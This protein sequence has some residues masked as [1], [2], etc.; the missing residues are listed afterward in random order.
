MCLVSIRHS[1]S[2]LKYCGV[3]LYFFNSRKKPRETKRRMQLLVDF[4]PAPGFR[5]PVNM[6]CRLEV[7]LA[8]TGHLWFGQ[9][10]TNASP[11]KARYWVSGQRFC[12]GHFWMHVNLR[13]QL[14]TYSSTTFQSVSNS[15]GKCAGPR[16]IYLP[17]LIIFAQT[18][19]S[20]MLTLLFPFLNFFF[21][22]EQQ[23][24]ECFL[25]TCIQFY[26]RGD[27]GWL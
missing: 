1:K 26:R 16:F 11:F 10:Y 25:H 15:C 22:Y 6:L 23:S 4:S 13:V 27:R 17:A 19:F 24:A 7:V 18:I 8:S 21:F 5:M 9:Y 12:I 20:V 3:S 14:Y 2:L